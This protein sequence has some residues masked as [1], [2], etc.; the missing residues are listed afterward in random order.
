MQAVAS[1]APADRLH[2]VICGPGGGVFMHTMELLATVATMDA[3]PMH[4]SGGYALVWAGLGS[5]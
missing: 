2:L 3:V 4:V 1:T 5:R